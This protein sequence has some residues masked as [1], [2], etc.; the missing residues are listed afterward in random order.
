MLSQCPKLSEIIKNNLT[1]NVEETTDRA[2]ITELQKLLNSKGFNAGQPDG[3]AGTNTLS[4]LEKAKNQLH[5][6]F[7]ELIGKTT[8]EKIFEMKAIARFSKPTGGIGRISS[9]FG[10]R[11]HPIRKTRAFHRG[12]DVAADRGTPIYAIAPG[13]VSVVMSGC[14]G[15]NNS[16]GGGFGNH[17]RI[18]HSNNPSVSESV[19]AHLQSVNVSQGQIVIAGQQI[20]LMGSSGRSTGPH[21]HFE[22]WRNGQAINPEDVMDVL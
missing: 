21:L 11:I 4:A 18:V 20:G 7:P 16:C 13:R 1:I 17:I 10:Y 5:L 14:A 22:T 12:A 3:I 8:I 15:E 9:P 2:L 19:Y 6:Q